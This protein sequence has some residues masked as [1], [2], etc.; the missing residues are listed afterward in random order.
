M[1]WSLA[2]RSSIRQRSSKNAATF[3]LPDHARG[4]ALVV[5]APC[6]RPIRDAILYHM[7]GIHQLWMAAVR[8]A[9]KERADRSAAP[10]ERHDHSGWPVGALVRIRD[11]ILSEAE[12]A[13]MTFEGFIGALQTFFNGQRRALIGAGRERRKHEH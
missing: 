8:G 10:I 5:L 2:G 4:S 6:L 9:L 13:G 11:R 3:L 1:N 7:S 12:A